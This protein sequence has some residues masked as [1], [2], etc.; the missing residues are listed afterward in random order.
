MMRRAST[1]REVFFSLLEGK[2][3]VMIVR[4]KVKNKVEKINSI[5]YS[6]ALQKKAAI[7]R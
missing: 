3:I 7:K 4:V 6:E 2:L 5:P 1:S